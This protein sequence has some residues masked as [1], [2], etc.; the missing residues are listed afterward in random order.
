MRIIA[1]KAKGR[2]LKVPKLSR[3]RRVRPLTDQVREALFNILGERVPDSYF[4]DLFAGTG[5][6]GI[7]A[8]SRGARI[9][10]F[11][12]LDR[13]VVSTI[14]E[15]LDACGLSDSAEV[16]SLDVLRAIKFLDK[17]DSR[18]DVIFLGAPYDS[19]ALEMAL[20]LIGGANIIND[21]GVVVA[22][23]RAK[24]MIADEFGV[25]KKARD[26]RYGDTVLSFYTAKEN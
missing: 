7:E 6:V 9:A 4:L 5:A 15:N 22:E 3:N 26:A 12:E 17:K 21:E 10:I 1:G 2:K 11:V 8:L 16:Y 23:H 19:P 20:E 25:L 18:F 24:H 13:A 14:R